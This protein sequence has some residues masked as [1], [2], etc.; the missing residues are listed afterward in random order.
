MLAASSSAAPAPSADPCDQCKEYDQND[1]IEAGIA[2]PY[3][4]AWNALHSALIAKD[5]T[6]VDFLSTAWYNSFQQALSPIDGSGCL[7][8]PAFST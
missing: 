8:Y 2:G 1:R 3:Q 5:Y 7:Y 6:N 4:G